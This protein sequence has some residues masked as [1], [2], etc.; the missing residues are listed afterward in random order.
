MI[1]EAFATVGPV[2]VEGAVDP[3][4]PPL[5]PKITMEQAAQ[6]AK[7]L[8]RGEPNR[9]KIALTVLKDKVRELV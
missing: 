7:S 1:E 6:F 8:V 5:P 9:G 3:L 4:E 2:I